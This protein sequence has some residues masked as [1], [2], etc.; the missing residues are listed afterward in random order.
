MVDRLPKKDKGLRKSFQAL[1]KTSRIR[2]AGK[3]GYLPKN[4]IFIRWKEIVPE[5]VEPM[6]TQRRLIHE[7]ICCSKEHLT[8]D[9]IFCEAKKRC[10]SIAFG[11]VYRNLKFLTESG[12]I[13]R[14]PM[15]DGPD[16][17]DRSMSPHEHL[18]CFVCKKLTDIPSCGLQEHIREKIGLDID[19]YVLTVRYVCPSCR[20]A[21]NQYR[22]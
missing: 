4:L 13:R 6:T 12:Q 20:N 1:R 8:A 14:I 10:P 15:P 21:A 7:I 17:Y 5:K 22:K 11:T 16:F 9:E 18:F 2:Q 3:L 19:S